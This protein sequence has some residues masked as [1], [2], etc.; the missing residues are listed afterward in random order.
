MHHALPWLVESSDN[1][2]MAHG[3]RMMLALAAATISTTTAHADVL[4]VFGEAH[5]GGYVGRG[6]SGDQKDEAFSAKAAPGAYGAKIGARFLIVEATIQHHQLVGDGLSTWTQFLAGIGVQADLG[7][8]KAK[9]AKNGPFVDLGIGAG[10][11]LGTGQQ[12]MPPLSNDE[13]TD[14]GFLI[15]G[16]IGFGK[17]LNS[18]LDIGISVPVSWGYFFKNGVDTAANDVST[19]YQ[20]LQAE[21]LLYLRLN[22]KLL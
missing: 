2:P 12:V 20:A 3:P 9:K 13:I 6:L 17:H 18:L 11:G 21:A 14:K 7:D 16:R 4:K 10:F 19:H 8:E 22:L 15:E 1:Q 5:G